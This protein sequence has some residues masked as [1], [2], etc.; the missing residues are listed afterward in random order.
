MAQLHLRI[1]LCHFLHHFPPQSGGV[2]HIG[3]IHTDDFLSPLH[4]DVKGLHGNTAD[5]LLIVGQ[6]VHGCHDAVHLSGMAL[7]EV[8]ASGQLPHDNHV[9][10]ISDNLPL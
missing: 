5:L 2:Q 9:K 8:K 10:S 3:L 7:P 1:I 6:G 4:G